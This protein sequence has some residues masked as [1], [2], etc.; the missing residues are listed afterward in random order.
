[1]VGPI[2]EHVKHGENKGPC[3]KW[4]RTKLKSSNYFITEYQLSY[5]C[6]KI[7]HNRPITGLGLLA[8]SLI[9]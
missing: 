2:W 7:N 1:M 8:A 5:V 9:D 4:E 3:W 6:D